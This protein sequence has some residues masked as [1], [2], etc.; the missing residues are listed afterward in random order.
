MSTHPETTAE[1]ERHGEQ[2]MC[3]VQLSRRSSSVWFVYRRSSV[4]GQGYDGDGAIRMLDEPDRD[5]AEHELLCPADVV[6]AHDEQV[7][8]VGQS[9][10]MALRHALVELSMHGHVGI[11]LGEA[12]QGL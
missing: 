9:K 3:P 8:L 4:G 11:L 6:G 7:H 1:D 5:G 10:Q 12:R 2:S